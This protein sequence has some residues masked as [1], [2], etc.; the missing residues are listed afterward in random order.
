MIKAMR[1][2]LCLRW[3]RPE[4][5]PNSDQ[6]GLTGMGIIF[7]TVHCTVCIIMRSG[8]GR[9]RGR[10]R[11]S[12]ASSG[13]G[14][15]GWCQYGTNC[16]STD[17]N[18]IRR[19]LGWIS[20]ESL[21]YYC[22]DRDAFRPATP[23][24]WFY[25]IAV[26]SYIESIHKVSQLN[27]PSLSAVD[28]GVFGNLQKLLTSVWSAWTAAAPQNRRLQRKNHHKKLLRHGKGSERGIVLILL[29]PYLPKVCIT[30]H[31]FR[32]WSWW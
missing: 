9:G 28:S 24:L 32:L 6:P 3:F 30:P 11:R 26:E 22:C 18:W 25:E 27:L 20:N 4:Q 10:G 13:S 19:H 12:C 8:R 16:T 17:K 15:N 23:G 1:P 31:I 2:P 14:W 21:K 5:V 29:L 7:R